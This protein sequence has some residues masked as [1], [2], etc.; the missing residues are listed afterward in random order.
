MLLRRVI[1][2]FLLWSSLACVASSAWALEYHGQVTFGGLPV[3][4]STVTVTATQGDKKVVA[5][6]DDQG[7]FSFADLTDGTWTLTIQMTGF[8][9]LKQDIAVAANAPAGT[10]ELKLMS[11]DQI[12]SEAKPVKVEVTQMAAIAA[13]SAPSA[14]TTAAATPGKPDAPAAKGAAAPTK[15]GPRAAAA[16]AVDAAQDATAAQANDGLLINGSVNNAATSQYSMNQAFGNNRNGGRSLYNG[17]AF[18]RLDNSTLDAAPYPV[19]GVAAPRPQFNNFTLGA[20]Y[21]G[22]L[23]IP[24]LMPRGPYFQLQYYRTQN[25]SFNTQSVIVPAGNDGAGNWNVTSAAVSA[26]YAP[27]NL[28]TVAPACDNY[29]LGKGFT[30]AQINA[31]TVQF[32][33]NIIP[34]AC[35]SQQAATLLTLYPQPNLT[36]SP[37]GQNYQ[38]PLNTSTHSDQASLNMNKQFGNK[39]NVN[40]NFQYQGSRSSNPSIFGFLDKQNQL[41]IGTNLNWNHRFSQRLSG[42]VSYSFTRQRSQ[43]LPFFANRNN[44]EAT[45]GI[46]GAS[47]A[48]AFWGPPSLGFASGIVGLNDGVSSYNRNETNGIGTNFYW[49]RF[50]HNLKFG[51]DFKRLEFNYLTQ[52]NPYGS[53]SFTGTS[54]DGSS[55]RSDFADFLLG[56]P[57]T[58][59]IAYGNADKYLRQSQYDLYITDDFRVNPEFSVQ[60]G[61]RWEYGAPITE[62]KGRLVNLDIAQGFTAEAPVLASTPKGTL[63]G[64]GYPTSLVHPDYSRPEPNIGIAWRPI[65]GSSLLIRSGFQVSNDTSVYQSSAYA[66]AQ[67]FPLSTSLSITNGVRCPFNLASPFSSTCSKTSQDSFAIDPNFKVGYVQAWN[68]SVQRD[69]PY[70]M[71]MVVTYNGIKGVHGVQEFLPNT[72]PPGAPCGSAVSGYRYRTSGGNLTREAGTLE[73]RRRL[74]NG[75]TA[76]LLYTYAKS[77]DDDYSLSGQ[78][79]ISSSGGIA[80]DWLHPEAQ[81]GLSTSDQRHLLNFTAQYT[82]GMGIGGKSLLSG[83]KG[84][85]YKEWTISTAINAG[86]G[87]PETVICGTCVATG[88]GTTGSVRPNILASPYAGAP[89]GYRLNAAAFAAPVGT[90][91]NVRRNSIEG[92]GQFSMNAS[93]QRTFRLHDRYTLD[94]TLNASNVLNHVVFTGWNTNWSPINK[95]FGAP[96]NANQMRSISLQFR[97]RF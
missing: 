36:G 87:L 86:T 23:N 50:R 6:S 78:G 80:Q 63:T 53:L 48:S 28:A 84:A 94:A 56:I 58:S 72:C 90:W 97:M 22:P 39:N 91:G 7:V 68:L 70:S 10:F 30:Q 75:F 61:V 77:L 82:T 42:S 83:W 64:Q 73:V 59:N 9:P 93:M 62:L 60:A 25:S 5:I 95:S 24:H 38:L 57:T 14:A 34:K 4:G 44:I 37:L 33:N 18:L 89:A 31:G 35:V 71:Q 2:G 29:L 21:G 32:A 92:P 26:V 49:N 43:L 76:R 67:Q 55:S 52:S 8:A 79:S 66:M 45:A 19:T 88:T 85:I 11:L 74:R 20:N 16:P 12:R 41:S 1:N 51:G 47:T 96:S 13:P 65:S 81:R 27:V 3:P 54:T 17:N 40:G 69:L 46:T 15:G